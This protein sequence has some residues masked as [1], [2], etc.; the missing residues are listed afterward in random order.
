MH[1]PHDTKKYARTRQQHTHAHARAYTRAH[2]H[3]RTQ[4]HTNAH[5]SLHNCPYALMRALVREDRD[6][7]RDRDRGS[8]RERRTQL[9][10]L[11]HAMTCTRMRARTHTYTCTCASCK[12]VCTSTHASVH[13]RCDAQTIDG[14]SSWQGSS[15]E[16]ARWRAPGF[17]TSARRGFQT[18]GRS[19][20][21]LR[22]IIHL[23]GWRSI[24]TV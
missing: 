10:A 23:S 24:A 21:S 2:T 17:W 14:Y 4:T 19:R 11:A 6:R 12:P 5:K 1:L 20:P 3:K 18:A 16:P 13:T 7:Q 22:A 8:N 9:V 15:A